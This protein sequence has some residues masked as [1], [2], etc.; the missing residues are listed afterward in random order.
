MGEGP[1]E[2]EGGKRHLWRVSLAPAEEQG[3]SLLAPGSSA[4]QGRITGQEKDV[5]CA[6]SCPRS[7]LWPPHRLALA[8]KDV[9]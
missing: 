8:R 7:P 5:T 4:C 3:R 9:F 6:D 2:A 1:A